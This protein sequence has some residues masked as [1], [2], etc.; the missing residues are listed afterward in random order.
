MIFKKESK[1]A[2]SKEGA[3]DVVAEDSDIDIVR[4]KQHIWCRII[5]V[6]CTI[7]TLDMQKE[8]ID[9]HVR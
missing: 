8:L 4:S 6:E 3:V 7:S 9:S 1:N 5:L 2:P